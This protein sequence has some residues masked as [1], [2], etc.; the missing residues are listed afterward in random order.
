M[1]AYFQSS[2]LI[3]YLVEK[4]WLRLHS[5]GFDGSR[6]RNSVNKSMADRGEP[7]GQLE[8][9]FF[10]YAREQAKAVGSKFDWNLLDAEVG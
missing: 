2:M 1:F 10:A 3:D 6:R 5:R 9:D 7:L 4:H 8:K